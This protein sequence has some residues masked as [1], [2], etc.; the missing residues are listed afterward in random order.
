MERRLIVIPGLA[1]NAL[2]LGA[3]VA[4]ETG[5]MAFSGLTWQK[6]EKKMLVGKDSQ[7]RKL[8]KL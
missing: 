5:F 1:A 6:D 2:P 8:K 7:Q 3:F 4:F